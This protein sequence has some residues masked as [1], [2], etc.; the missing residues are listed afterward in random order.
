[1][2]LFLERPG[3]VRGLLLVGPERAKLA[4]LSEQAFHSIRP[5]RARQLVLEVTL[6]GVEP[7]ALELTTVLAPQCAQEM[8]LLADVIEPCEPDVAVLPEK[9]WEIPVAAHRHDGDALGPEVA[10]TATSKGLDGAAVARAFNEYYS[11]QLHRCI[12]SGSI[13]G[14][15]PM[16]RYAARVFPWIIF[17]LVAVPLVV[18]GFVASRRRTRAGEHPVGEDAQATALTEQ[19]FA[20]AEAYEAKWRE[21]D[22]KSYHEE[23]LP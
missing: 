19:E 18:V 5:D 22:E 20:E 17:A 10:A 1:M 14:Y 13:V 23:R 8:P 2:Q 3:T 21:E 11:A 4:L 9:A 6:A 12:R 7:G 15:L 16:K